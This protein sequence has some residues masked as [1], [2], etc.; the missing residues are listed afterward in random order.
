MKPHLLNPDLYYFQQVAKSKTL[1]AAADLLGVSQPALSRSLDKLEQRLNFKLFYR[2]RSGIQLTEQGQRFLQKIKDI[3]ESLDSAL[4]SMQNESK[5][6]S[7]EFWIGGHESLLK[8]F[9]LP[10]FPQLTQEFSQVRFHLESKSSRETVNSIL[11]RKVDIGLA[12]NPIQ[13]SHLIFRSLGTVKALFFSEI[14]SPQK[15][16]VNPQMVDMNRLLKGL[17][18]KL[19]T[20]QNVFFVEN[21]DI[22][23]ELVRM[24]MGCGL[25][26][27]HIGKRYGLNRQD[28]L[29]N[30]IPIQFDL[31]LVASAENSSEKKKMILRYLE[32]NLKF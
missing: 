24:R 19:L 6:P 26:P 9:V 17:R 32:K 12:V 1:L 30:K 29:S 3:Q 22:I 16:F 13:Y 8:D 10:I 25:L 20:E 4:Q 28:E 18:K 11:Q 23:A 21:Y 2:S 31:K 7:G 5:S 27:A 15:I 14:P